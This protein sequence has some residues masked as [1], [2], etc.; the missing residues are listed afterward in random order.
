[1]WLL[2]PHPIE[3]DSRLSVEWLLTRMEWAHWR[4]ILNPAGESQSAHRADAFARP[5]ILAPA[6]PTVASQFETFISMAPSRTLNAT[7]GS[8]WNSRTRITSTNFGPFPRARPLRW[9]RL[10]RLRSR[11]QSFFCLIPW[12]GPSVRDDDRLVV[13][14]RTVSRVVRDQLN[15]HLTISTPDIVG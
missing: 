9:R 3:K 8:T 11:G 2:K 4:S 10:L 13:N 14:V 5:S 1:M 6:A 15:S 12:R 7:S